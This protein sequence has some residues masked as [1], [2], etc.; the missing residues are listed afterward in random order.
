MKKLNGKLFAAALAIALMSTV[1]LAD[2]GSQIDSF[3]EEG[4]KLSWKEA[5]LKAPI[6]ETDL[7]S[8]ILSEDELYYD[9]DSDDED[10]MVKTRVA[11]QKTAQQHAV[12]AEKAS[13]SASGFW[14]KVQTVLA[15]I[16]N[17]FKTALSSFVSVR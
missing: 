5:F 7:S 1:T 10:Y 15:P 2:P 9:D 8:S 16:A 6:A 4:H 11:Q 12:D 3:K 13:S 17:W 14:G